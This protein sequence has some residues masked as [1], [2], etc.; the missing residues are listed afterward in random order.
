VTRKITRG[1]ARI[2]VRGGARAGESRR[3]Q[4]GIAATQAQQQR[5]CSGPAWTTGRARPSRPRSSTHHLAAC[6][7]PRPPPMRPQLGL[8]QCLYLGN[9]DAR[10]DWGHAR[11]YVEMQWLM[12]QQDSPRDYVIA[13]GGARGG[14]EHGG[15]LG[16]GRW[17]ELRKLQQGSPR[18]CVI[19]TGRGGVGAA[20]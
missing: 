13:T 9:L 14:G 15:G 18:D 2:K 3:Q 20:A 4:A 10:R 7:R 17:G 8:Q 5:A 19:A 11:D 16:V 1:L 6:S 12:L